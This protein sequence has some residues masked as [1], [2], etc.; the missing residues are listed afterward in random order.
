[1]K[2]YTIEEKNYDEFSETM[3]EMF[4]LCTHYIDID[5]E[6]KRVNGRNKTYLIVIT[7]DDNEE[8]LWRNKVLEKREKEKW[9]R[10]ARGTRRHV[11]VDTDVHIGSIGNSS[12]V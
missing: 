1:M 10:E 3:K 12:W 8:R 11:W 5:R 4:G 2:Y 6:T 9:E 7:T